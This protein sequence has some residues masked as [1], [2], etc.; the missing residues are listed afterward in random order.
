MSLG[1]GCFVVGIVIH[2]LLHSL[3]MHHEQSRNDRDTYIQL[4]EQNMNPGLIGWCDII[5][6]FMRIRKLPIRSF[7]QTNTRREATRSTS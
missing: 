2:E 6:K 7:S 4:L 1:T 3:G 5:C